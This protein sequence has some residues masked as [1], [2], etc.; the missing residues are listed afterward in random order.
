MLDAMSNATFLLGILF[1]LS[2]FILKRRRPERRKLAIG[3][4]ALAIPLLL[5]WAYLSVLPAF[6]ESFKAGY[7]A[8]LD[9]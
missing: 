6:I 3:L 9:Q 5:I 8:G 7:E 2:G 4:L 1:L